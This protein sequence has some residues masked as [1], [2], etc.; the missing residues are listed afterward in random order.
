M[1]EEELLD[2]V[3]SISASGPAFVAKLIEVYAN[4]GVESGIDKETSM[5]LTLKTFK[6]TI[7]HLEKMSAQELIK[8]VATPNGMTEAGLK[9]LESSN[10]KEILKDTIKKATERSKELGK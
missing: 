9:I 10:L 5:E 7:K 1:L 8:M 6:G 4:A 3:G 2:A